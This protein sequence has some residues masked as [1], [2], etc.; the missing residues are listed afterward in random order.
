MACW[1]SPF[2]SASPGASYSITA[3]GP[4]V[5]GRGSL[6]SPRRLA[7]GRPPCPAQDADAGRGGQAPALHPGSEGEPRVGPQAQPARRSPTS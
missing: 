6:R 3:D 5:R 2:G 7:A 4:C 1:P